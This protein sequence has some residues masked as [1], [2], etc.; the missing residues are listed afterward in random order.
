M[1]NTSAMISPY[2]FPFTDDITIPLG[3]QRSK[4]I[5]QNIFGQQI[6]KGEEL[7][8]ADTG[9]LGLHSVR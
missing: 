6:F 5:A 8:A 3:G 7:S 4:D 2:L 9:P 1:M